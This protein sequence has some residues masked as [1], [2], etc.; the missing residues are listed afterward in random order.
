MKRDKAVRDPKRSE[1][2]SSILL[3]AVFSLA[4]GLLL[5]LTPDKAIQVTT[6]IIGILLLVLGGWAVFSYLRIHV[7]ERLNS[8]RLAFG[9]ISAFI[10]I[11]LFI[12]PDE[13]KNL[14]P[15]VWG[16]ALIC[17]A[18]LKV[19]YS[20]DEKSVKVPKWW[21][22][23]IFAAFSLIIGALVLL[24]F[25]GDAPNYLIIGI[26]MV[27]EAL[28]DLYV[29]FTLYRSLRKYIS[30]QEAAAL[31]SAAAQA[32]ASESSVPAGSETAE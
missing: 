19:Q 28:L 23:L 5:I 9:L 26:M 6:Y 15:K 21:L 29:W 31:V 32:P 25:G 17:G 2:L 24:V 20:L 22:M 4:C 7:M 3:P 13:L 11:M 1:H 10:G 8:N 27:S 30:E 16:L 18:F 12:F 14:L